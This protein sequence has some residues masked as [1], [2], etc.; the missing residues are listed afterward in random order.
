MTV[1]IS[2]LYDRYADAQKAVSGLEAAGVSHS[3]ISIVANNSDNW[4]DRER[5]SIAIAMAS[6]TALRALE[7]ERELARVWAARLACWPA[8]GSWRSRV[9]VQSSRRAGS[10]QRQSALPQERRPAALLVL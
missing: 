5:K 9:S 7:R 8:S 2:R 1:T 10:R 4:Y 6:M 3:D